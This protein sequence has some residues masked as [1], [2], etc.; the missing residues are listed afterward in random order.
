MAPS[1]SPAGTG[2]AVSVRGLVP[3]T[4]LGFTLPHEHLTVDSRG[5]LFPAARYPVTTPLSITSLAQARR[6]PRSLADNLVLDD[7]AAVVEDL[8]RYAE[9]GGSSLVELTPPGMGRDFGRLRALSDASGIAVIASTGYY[10]TYGHA[11]RVAGRTV[12]ELAAEMVHDLRHGDGDSRCG[13]IGEIGLSADPDPD[14]W[15]VLTAALAAQHLTGAPIWIHVTTLKPVESLLEFLATRSETPDRVVISHMDFSLEDLTL[16]R[17]ALQA[18]FNVEFDLFGFPGWNGGN[19][20]DLPT[21]ARRLR[22]LADLTDMH[23]DQL[24]I[25]HDVCMK[26]QLS[27]W[28]GFGYAHILESVA[29]MCERLFGSDDMVR[30]FGIDNAA[31]VLAWA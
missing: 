7:D 26:M 30:H 20:I 3:A 17:K 5:L 23:P 16:H 14:E 25:S 11:G 19:F 15:K 18:G 8:I 6:V 29:P 4:D 28:G 24:F 31:R 22:V 1:V 10:V 13:A 21:D 2:S 9:V 27:R 12:E